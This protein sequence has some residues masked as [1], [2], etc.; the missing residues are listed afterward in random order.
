M[1][2]LL[3]AARPA[4][5]QETGAPAPAAAAPGTT[6]SASWLADLPTGDNLFAA[7][8]GMQPDVVADEFSG[9]GLSAGQSIRIG[10][11]GS[12]FTQTAF[13]LD[14][15][16]I[17]DPDGSG[18][19]LFFP[20]LMFWQ[21]VGVAT[22]PRAVDV[23]AA[24]PVV[25]LETR[26]PGSHWRGSLGSSFTPPAFVEESSSSAA[27]PIARFD[28][29]SH[30]DAIVGG[31]LGHSRFRL[32]AGS[33]LTRA[34]Q[35][36]RTATVAQ[37]ARV[38]SGF[39]QLVFAATPRDRWRTFVLEQQVRYPLAN[40]T[41]SRPL[42]ASADDRSVALQSIWE[43]G[44]PGGVG[45][46]GWVSYAR[47]R[48]HADTGA[49]DPFTI[50]RITNGPVPDLVDA[51]A[52]TDHRWSIGGAMTP[53]ARVIGGV[54]HAWTAGAE[55]GGAGMRPAAPFTGLVGELVAGQP[56]RVWQYSAPDLTSD[57]HETTVAAYVDDRMTWDSRLTVEAGLRYDGVSASAA[58]AATGVQWHTWLP[59]ASVRW[60]LP[61]PLGL[62]LFTNYARSAYRLP[63]QL[64][65]WGDPA[66]PVADVFRW[67]APAGTT[68]VSA[69]AL[70]PL[71]QRIGPGTGGNPAFSRIDPA[72]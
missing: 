34:S 69:A 30:A 41:V 18:T 20:D 39:A 16:D 58:G 46:R 11:L 15:I 49:T 60:A 32:I 22:D 47:R 19:P 67:D 72:L 8:Q 26:L 45:W 66:A 64:L 56:A 44:V 54:R 68:A 6:V 9:G 70:G 12:A 52:G 25:S 21:Q 14:G 63:L 4:P 33:D 59:R 2:L 42:T 24:G 1:L 35:F 36:E 62:A 43:H 17:T 3:S 10:A 48:R 65:A 28:S 29:W 71:V 23:N 27:P 55:V 5:A 37:P 57:R 38:G 40:G 13:R 7:L 61:L 50:D 51:G 53:A 31:P